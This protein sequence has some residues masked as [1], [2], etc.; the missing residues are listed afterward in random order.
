MVSMQETPNL[1]D[2]KSVPELEFVEREAAPES[3]MKLG[4]Q[5]HLGGLPLSDISLF[6]LAR[7]SIVVKSPRIIG[8]KRPIYSPQTAIL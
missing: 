4:I 5:L 3:T 8:Y 7:V 6:P 1:T 2:C